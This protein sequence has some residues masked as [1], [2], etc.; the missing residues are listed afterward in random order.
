[1]GYTCLSF[2]MLD[3]NLHDLM[4]DQDYKPMGLNEIRPVAKQV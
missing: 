2:E 3:R 4:A 1:M